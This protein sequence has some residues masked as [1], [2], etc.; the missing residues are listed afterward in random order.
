MFLTNDYE[1]KFRQNL[2]AFSDLV[3]ISHGQ[4]LPPKFFFNTCFYFMRKI[5]VC[6]VWHVMR[7]LVLFMQISLCPSDFSLHEFIRNLKH[8][9]CSTSV[10]IILQKSSLA[11]WASKAQNSLVWWKNPLA[12]SYQTWLFFHWENLIIW[13]A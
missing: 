12:L 5:S 8:L 4:H 1:A 2:I 6:L 13:L 7:Y 10:I 9:F 3:W 11:L